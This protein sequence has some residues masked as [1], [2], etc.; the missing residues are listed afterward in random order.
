MSGQSASL[1]DR[2]RRSEYT[3]ENRCMPCTVVNVVIAAVASAALGLVAF[4]L[5]PVAFAASLVVIYL[6]GYLVPGTPTLTKQY[7]PEPVLQA[8][9]KESPETDDQTFETLQKLEYERQNAVDPDSFLMEVGAIEVGPDGE[10]Y[11]LTEQFTATFETHAEDARAVGTRHEALAEIFDEDIDSIEQLDRD[12]PAVNVG[13]RVRKWPSDAALIADVAT[14]V[15]LT[16]LTDRWMEVPTE[17]RKRILESL[18]GFH[19]DCPDCG[20]SVTFRED[21]VDSCC[22]Q[23]QVKTFACEGC[24]GH[25]LEFDQERVGAEEEIKGMTP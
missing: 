5:A 3:G 16:E 2:L 18:R 15:T 1:L 4:P 9:G 25:L 19:D 20:G 14:H 21:I 23:H 24:G 13:I 10:E 7:L 12:Y 11:Q 8:F 22:G 17:Q 6:R